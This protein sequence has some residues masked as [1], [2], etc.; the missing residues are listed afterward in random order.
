MKKKLYTDIN[1]KRIDNFL[2]KHLETANNLKDDVPPF[3]SV[4]ISINGACNRRCFFCPRVDEEGY[5]NILESLDMKI[6]D[7]LIDDLTSI[8]YQGRVAFSG[9]C[10]PLLSKNLDQYIFKIKKKTYKNNS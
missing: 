5:P 7:R 6:F 10:E 9:F 3:S 4:E 2:D 8:N 1:I